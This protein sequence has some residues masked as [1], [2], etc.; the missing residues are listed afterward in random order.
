MVEV[1]SEALF[2]SPH[3]HRYARRSVN[4]YIHR[5]VKRIGIA[6]RVSCHTFRRTINTL[7]KKMG[8][9]N[10]DRRILLCHKVNDINYQCYVRLNLED[11]LA[12]RDKWDPYKDF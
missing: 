11:Y 2:L 3:K 6:K 12:L 1:D 10:E 8:C 5:C 7:R 9:P 4:N